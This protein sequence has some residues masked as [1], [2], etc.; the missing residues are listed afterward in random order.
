MGLLT[1]SQEKR[2]SLLLNSLMDL[3]PVPTTNEDVLLRVFTS[4]FQ[5]ISIPVVLCFKYYPI[6]CGV[7]VTQNSWN[8]GKL[9]GHGY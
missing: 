8:L 7:G 6:S 9:G 1:V 5:G 3:R 4:Y 2:R